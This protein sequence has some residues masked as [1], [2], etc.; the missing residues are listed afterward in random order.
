[1]VIYLYKIKEIRNLE[2]S[3][4]SKQFL[5]QQINSKQNTFIVTSK[6]YDIFMELQL[7]GYTMPNDKLINRIN[8]NLIQQYRLENISFEAILTG[9]GEKYFVNK[10]IQSFKKA[11]TFICEIGAIF[12]AS[13][14]S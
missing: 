7:F 14:L 13:Y 6:N 5:K 9:L 8:N 3:K 12:L 1:M 10:R 2:L 11:I 4:K